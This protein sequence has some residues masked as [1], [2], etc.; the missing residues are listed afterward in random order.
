MDGV[1]AAASVIAVAQ[2]AWQ[3]LDQCQTYYKEVKG[4][5][6]DILHLQNEVA[7]LGDI[8]ET[9]SDDTDPA[10]PS[11]MA[12]LIKEDG[13]LQQ[14]REALQDLNSKLK[15]G[16]GENKMRQ[17]GVRALKWPFSSKDVEKLLKVIIRHKDTFNLA[18][19]GDNM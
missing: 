6:K 14:C 4:A 18:L 19:T 9:L 10:N 16:E 5:R 11:S 2:I 13:P 3:V 1:S 7:L 8:L 17:F 15:P 12:L